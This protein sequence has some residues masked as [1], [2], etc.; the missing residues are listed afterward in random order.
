MR[1]APMVDSNRDGHSSGLLAYRHNSFLPH[2]HYH[3]SVRERDEHSGK[4]VDWRNCAERPNDTV[5][6]RTPHRMPDKVR[7][8]RLLCS[9]DEV[10]CL[11]PLGW[12]IPSQEINFITIVTGCGARQTLIEGRKLKL[13]IHEIHASAPQTGARNVRPSLRIHHRNYIRIAFSHY[14]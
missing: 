14:P 8:S 4:L 13:P 1:I 7:I 10:F 2:A 6:L 12:S 11:L 5:L 9:L 3:A